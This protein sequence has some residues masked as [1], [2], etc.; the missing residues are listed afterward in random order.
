MV[1]LGY[2]PSGGIAESYD[3]HYYFNGVK[4]PLLW[5]LPLPLL[6]NAEQ[7]L[8]EECWINQKKIP[9]V[10][11]QW[12]SPSKMVGGVKS[13]LESNPKPARDSWRAQTNPVCTRTQ[14]LQRD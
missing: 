12:R 1:F 4:I 5:Y 9:H 3:Y 8:T 11:G 13:R 6:C 14:R 7:P 2:M 10:Q